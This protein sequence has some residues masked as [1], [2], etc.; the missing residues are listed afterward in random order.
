MI[1][2]RLLQAEEFFFVWM[3]QQLFI[4]MEISAF[5]AVCVKARQLP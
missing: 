5:T 4:N 3:I 2:G 1:K